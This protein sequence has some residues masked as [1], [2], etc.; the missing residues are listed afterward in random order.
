[1]QL[2]QPQQQQQQDEQQQLPSGNLLGAPQQQP[3]SSERE[4]LP[5]LPEEL[6]RLFRDLPSQ[7]PDDLLRANPDLLQKEL[8]SSKEE[9]AVS[10]KKELSSSRE[11][12]GAVSLNVTEMANEDS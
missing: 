7:F 6:Q 11:E 5:P 10:Q 12:E 3:P 9:G 2:P 8:S 1:M 4:T